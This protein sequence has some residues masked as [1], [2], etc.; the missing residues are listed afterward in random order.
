MRLLDRET[1]V[2]DF[3]RL[4]FTDNFLPQ[5]QKVLEQP[6]GIL[7]VT[8]PTGSGKTTTLYTALSKLHTS[9]VK[10]ITVQDPVEYQ[11]E[12]LNKTQ[13]KTQIGLDFANPMRRILRQDPE[14]TSHGQMRDLETE[15]TAIKPRPEDGAGG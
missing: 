8:G 13:A 4:G 2:F 12:G 10:I 7:L 6:H 11:S 9:D 15:H 1:V 14:T 3:H 5:F